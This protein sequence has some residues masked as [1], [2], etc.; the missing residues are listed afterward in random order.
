LDLP[1]ANIDVEKLLPS[2]KVEDGLRSMNSEAVAAINAQTGHHGSTFSIKDVEE[3]KAKHSEEDENSSFE[4][5][6]NTLDDPK[7]EA[8][9]AMSFASSKADKPAPKVAP[10]I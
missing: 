6:D 10:A 8:Q 5:V 1:E 3:P 9:A 4:G 7:S 2:P